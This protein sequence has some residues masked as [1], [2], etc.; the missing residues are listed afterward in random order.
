M[1]WKISQMMLSEKPMLVTL[2]VFE[3]LMR[4]L[5]LL[6]LKASKANC[7]LKLAR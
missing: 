4:Q 6:F 3:V 5:H 1:L 2:A 7:S